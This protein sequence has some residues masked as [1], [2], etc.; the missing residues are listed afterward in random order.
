MQQFHGV[1]NEKSS[2]VLKTL[3]NFGTRFVTVRNFFSR[4][5]FFN[6]L[7]FLSSV[8][9]MS[10]VPLSRALQVSLCRQS[11]WSGSLPIPWTLNSQPFAVDVGACKVADRF[12]LAV[13]HECCASAGKR[14]HCSCSRSRSRRY[15]RTVELGSGTH[16]RM[17]PV[18]L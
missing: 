5:S 2:S 9:S 8:R 13:P 15:N 4:S 1:L 11:K 18:L 16:C 7:D 17:Y 12:R 14:R 3:T 10:F 6:A